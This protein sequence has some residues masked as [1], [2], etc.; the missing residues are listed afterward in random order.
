M[1]AREFS[2]DVLLPRSTDDRHFVEGRSLAPALSVFPGL[3]STLFQ[4]LDGATAC[5]GLDEFEARGVE[6][7]VH[8]S[9]LDNGLL[10]LGDE[11]ERGAGLHAHGSEIDT[12][13]FTRRLF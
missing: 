9:Q 6:P 1:R 7:V 11:M 5:G 10:G 12:A 8:A 13:M 3:E 2:R 4:N